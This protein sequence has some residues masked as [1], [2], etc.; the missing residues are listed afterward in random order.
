MACVCVCVCVLSVS[1]CAFKKKD[2]CFQHILVHPLR[3]GK[4]GSLVHA[5]ER[6]EDPIEVGRKGGDVRR[7]DLTEHALSNGLDV[8]VGQIGFARLDV[9]HELRRYVF[10][11]TH[12]VGGYGGLHAREAEDFFDER[13][14]LVVEILTA[15]DWERVQQRLLCGRFVC[16]ARVGH[17]LAVLTDRLCR[18]LGDPLRD[19]AMCVVAP[20]RRGAPTARQR[21]LPQLVDTSVQRFRACTTSATKCVSPRACLR[22]AAM[23]SWISSRDGTRG[24]SR[25]ARKAW[26]FISVKYC[27]NISR[28]RSSMQLALSLDGTSKLCRRSSLEWTE[29]ASWYATAWCTVAGFPVMDCTALLYFAVP[30]ANGLSTFAFHCCTASQRRSALVADHV[31]QPQIQ[32]R[33]SWHSGQ[34]LLQ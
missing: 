1:V 30:F 19:A 5:A 20:F 23:F 22:R 24:D 26:A 21:F 14:L 27:Q 3:F 6:G 18:K 10:D 16:A 17:G 28:L 7:V 31:C 4:E 9:L 8:E 32:S 25:A 34:S 15:Q 12:H 13:P 29:S 11:A 2:A 33:V